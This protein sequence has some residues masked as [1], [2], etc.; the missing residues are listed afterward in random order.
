MSTEEGRDVTKTYTTEQ[1]IQKLER[2][3]KALKENKAFE[4]QVAGER[5]Y[6]PA[7]TEFSIEHEQSGSDHELEFQF[8]WSDED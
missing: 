6:I 8:R 7:E 2:L 4:I 5:L 1:N 3:V